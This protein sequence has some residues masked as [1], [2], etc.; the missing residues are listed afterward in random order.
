MRHNV[1]RL[2]A[3]LLIGDVVA[4]APLPLADALAEAERTGLATHP[5]WLRLLHYKDGDA[6]AASEVLDDDFFLASNG[7]HSPGDELRATLSA[8]LNDGGADGDD[9][10]SCRFPA[11]RQFLN[12]TLALGLP[13][14]GC[15]RLEQWVNAEQLDSISLMMI[16]G[17]FGNPASTFGHILI[18]INNGSVPD[19]YTLLDLGINFGALVPENENTLVYIVRGL[20]GKYQAGFSDQDY[21]RAD[22]TY[23]R[24]EF[25]DMW[26]Y[27]LNLSAYQ[28][29]LMLNHLWEIA[30]RKFRYYF[31]KGNCAYRIAELLELVTEA[32]FVA[33]INLWYAP[34][35]TFHRL[36]AVDASLESQGGLITSVTYR[37][38]AQRLFYAQVEKLSTDEN[39]LLNTLIVSGGDLGALDNIDA[40]GR[41]NVL[42]VLLAYYQYRLAGVLDEEADANVRNAKD[43]ALRARLA[44]PAVSQAPQV[45]IPP[46]RAPSSAAPPSR[47]AVGGG[48]NDASDTY[49]YA[50]YAAFSY[51][52]VGNNLLDYSSLVMADLSVGF[53]RDGLRLEKFDFV[54]ARKVN[55]VRS[56]I[57][58]ES[59]S[60]WEVGFGSRREHLGCSDCREAFFEGAVGKSTGFGDAAAVSAFVGF[61]VATGTLGSSAFTRVV[62]NVGTA[63]RWGS[64]LG[65]TYAFFPRERDDRVTLRWRS[66]LSLAQRH[67]VNFDL[68]H[69]DVLDGRVYYAY[70][71]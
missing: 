46:R 59:T 54:R 53:D 12:R 36:D 33:D 45:A 19:G 9:R 62:L 60:S 70:R 56:G 27:K 17:Y 22:L 23:S 31:L 1:L 58:D 49:G 20:T 28:T 63:E 32:P 42:D 30:G 8:L 61:D 55:L 43:D 24:T 69:D 64:E 29:R 13:E 7:S 38:S 3:L 34:I 66:R 5:V 47:F 21:Y 51:E 37:P 48:Y 6:A 50:S 44:L 25:R 52:T 18:K 26:E 35:T 39:A 71:W 16:S 14:T 10:A 4:G 41:A 11:R 67:E 40:A 57:H 2:I 65:A 68:A 15:P